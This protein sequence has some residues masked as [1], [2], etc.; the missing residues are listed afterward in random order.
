[1][2][3]IVVRALYAE[4]EAEY[5]TKSILNTVPDWG[6]F[7]DEGVDSFL[8]VAGHHVFGHHLGGVL[9]SLRQRHF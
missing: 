8:C 3:L 6:T 2:P 7:G 1:M 5:L 4:L 9:I